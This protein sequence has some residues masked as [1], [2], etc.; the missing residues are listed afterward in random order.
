MKFK[1]EKI[2]EWPESWQGEKEDIPYGQEIVGLMIPFIE[3]MKLS[4]LSVKTINEHID[5]LWM[6]G[7]NIIEDLNW[8]DKTDLIPPQEM[9]FESVDSEGGPLIHDFD[10]SQQEE[11]DATC[12]KFYKHLKA[13]LAAG[14]LLSKPACPKQKNNA[15]KKK[16]TES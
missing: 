13:R 7:A 12:R 15:Q 9:L 1:D 2:D 10:E 4:K 8:F 11:F 5:N 14:T 3:E 16:K 6:L